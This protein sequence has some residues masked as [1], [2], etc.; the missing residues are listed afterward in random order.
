MERLQSAI[1]KARDA[2][3]GRTAEP[4]VGASPSP[5]ETEPANPLSRALHADARG[6]RVNESA[7]KSLTAFEPD[8]ALLVKNRILT[9]KAS[10][11]AMSFDV[12]RTKLLQQIRANGWRR[13]AVTSPGPACG[14]TTTV[15]NL[16][17][18]LARQ[19]DVRAL[20]VEADLRRPSMA[21]ILGLTGER[22]F[23]KVLAGKAPP[24]EHLVRFGANLALATNQRPA[25]NSAELL[26]A[27]ETADVLKRLEERLDPTIT[28]FDLPPMLANDDALAA[29][30]LVDCVLI[31]VAAEKTRLSEVDI[32]E[33]EVAARSNVVGIVLNKCRYLEEH[34]GYGYGYGY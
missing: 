7:W 23:S 22:Q 5:P 27:P 25:N 3:K 29:L 14:K 19:G 21:K 16:A 34:E 18:S 32:C 2:R 31:V 15:L 10:P 9:L 20:V 33:R 30:G 13:V 28:L 1:Q 26:H 17:F 11:Q 12:L 4:V 24:E 6:G 8:P